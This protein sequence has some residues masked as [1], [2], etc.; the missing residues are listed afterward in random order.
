M[1]SG[2]REQVSKKPYETPVLTRYG[3]VQHL[4]QTNLP[5]R[6]NDGGAFPSTFTAID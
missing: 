3:A 5:R 2:A 1:A 4:T 6:S